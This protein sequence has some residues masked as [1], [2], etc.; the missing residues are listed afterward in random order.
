[1]LEI[2]DQSGHGICSWDKS[3]WNMRYATGNPW[4][5]AKIDSFLTISAM[6]RVAFSWLGAMNPGSATWTSFHFLPC[7]ILKFDKRDVEFESYGLKIVVVC[8]GCGV[9]KN[10]DGMSRMN[11]D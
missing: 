8:T 4:R 5:S 1:M 6:S 11:E 7:L 3:S 9:W 10:V 2:L